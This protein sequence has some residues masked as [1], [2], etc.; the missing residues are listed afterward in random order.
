[1]RDGWGSHIQ[2]ARLL[3][4]VKVTPAFVT[5]GS[6]CLDS[7]CEPAQRA[8][9]HLPRTHTV[10]ITYKG[11]KSRNGQVTTAT[12][13][14]KTNGSAIPIHIY[15]FTHLLHIVSSVIQSVYHYKGRTLKR[16]IGCMWGKIR[17]SVW[18]KEILCEDNNIVDFTIMFV[19][20][21][22]IIL[23]EK[24]ECHHKLSESWDP[25]SVYHCIRLNL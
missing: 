3:M 18:L 24:S 25:P 19:Y 15:Q 1:M 5:S 21:C 20:F 10:V 23:G 9:D 22:F 13:V 17:P 14:T 4:K 12:R 7:P 16:Y 11:H 2:V 8:S 6:R